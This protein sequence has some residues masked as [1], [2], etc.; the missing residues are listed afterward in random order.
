MLSV[1]V[2][3]LFAKSTFSCNKSV[4]RPNLENT[5][6]APAPSTPNPSNI[7]PNAVALAPLFF[8]PSVTLTKA[9]N[10]SLFT[11]SAKSFAFIPAT[12]AKSFVF[13]VIFK[14]ILLIAVPPRSVLTFNSCKV[15]DSPKTCPEVNPKLIP[16]PPIRFA[17][18]EITGPVAIPDAP[19]AFT[20][21]PMCNISA[22]ILSD[23]ISEKTFRSFPIVLEISSAPP[24]NSEDNTTT[25]L[26]VASVN[27]R[28]SFLAIPNW[29]AEMLCSIF[30][31]QLQSF[32]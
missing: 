1:F 6:L 10:K 9:P 18:S 28:I 8:A 27:A 26:S 19:N 14:R 5:S 3:D 2:N 12:F 20:A 21:L 22:E 30:E 24:P 4:L 32:R 29:P 23:L 7:A 13:C 11:S 25:N 31:L 15:A 17:K 16:T